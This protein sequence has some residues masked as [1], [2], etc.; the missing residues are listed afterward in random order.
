MD[1][2]VKLFAQAGISVVV[3]GSIAWAFKYWI[4]GVNK[5]LDELLRSVHVIELK[6]ANQAGSSNT[7]FALVET[8]VSDMAERIAKT[9]SSTNRMWN[10]LQGT[11]I[12]RGVKDD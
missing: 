10:V 4:E 11:E 12:K 8:K 5:K 2:W 9:E 1:E 7:R 3:M 6:D